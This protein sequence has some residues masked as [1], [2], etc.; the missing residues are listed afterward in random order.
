[1]N[2]SIALNCILILIFI[3]LIDCWILRKAFLTQL[4]LFSCAVLV[5]LIITKEPK[6]MSRQIKGGSELVDDFPYKET[7]IQTPTVEYLTNIRDKSLLDVKQNKNTIYLTKS[8]ETYDLGEA[9]TDL[10]NERARMRAN[11][12]GK[13]SPYKMWIR[14][15]A[16][17]Q[18]AGTPEQQREYIYRNYKEATCFSPVVSKWVYDFLLPCEGG[19]VY[20]PFA[21]W[22]DRMIGAGCSSKVKSYTTTDL[23]E[24]CAV[25][26]DKIIKDM[27]DFNSEIKISYKI[28]DALEEM[29]KVGVQIYDLVFTSPPYFDFEQYNKEKFD[30][31][32]FREWLDT[33]YTDFI[34]YSF[35]ILK[36]GGYFAV[37]VGDTYRTPNFVSETQKICDQYGKLVYK[38]IVK[39]KREMPILVYQK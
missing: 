33:F 35:N 18:A 34:K 26:Y 31:R 9:V 38:I 1:M 10:Y 28:T 20:D 29:Q 32:D 39:S 8:Q 11:I 24:M 3:I 16:K 12:Y 36:V 15:K 2:S 30:V 19:A 25:G 23:N 37:H 14:D 22:G 7:Y 27:E 21:G 13:S 6:Q 5:Y 4:L 17:I